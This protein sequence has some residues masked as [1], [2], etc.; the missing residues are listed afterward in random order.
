MRAADIARVSQLT[1]RTNQFNC[2]TIRRSE[3]EIEKMLRPSELECLTVDLRD[4]FGDYG[5]VGVM[6][7]KSSG[8]ALLV[9]TMLLSCRALGRRVEH[10]MLAKLAEI[11]QERGLARVEIPFHPTAKNKPAFEFLESI[12]KDQKQASN[13]GYI[14]RFALK[15]ALAAAEDNASAVMTAAEGGVKA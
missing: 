6:I 9:D 4:R 1:Q 12:G 13:G 14:F 11:A 8:D 15:L 10:R 3:V 5:M 7:F 2:T